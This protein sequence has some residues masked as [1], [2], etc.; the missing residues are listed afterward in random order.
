MKPSLLK[1]SLLFILLPFAMHAQFAL[2][3]TVKMLK[4]AGL[5]PD[6][7]QGV[8]ALPVTGKPL[9]RHVCLVNDNVVAVTIDERSVILSNI[10][11]YVKQP[12]DTIIMGGYHGM[13][14]IL[15]RD[16]EPVGYLCGVNSNWFRPYNDIVGDK[17]ISELLKSPEQF[18]LS[19]AD[20]PSFP[21]PMHPL[22]VYRKSYTVDRTHTSYH[23]VYPL[24]HEIYL[25]FSE[26]LK[27]GANYTI[28]FNDNPQFAEPLT[29][30]FDDKQLRSEAIHVNLAGY[31]SGNKKTALL[32]TWMG[33]GGSL[34]IPSNKNFHIIKDESGSTVFSGTTKLLS[35]DE[36]EIKSY[37]QTNIYTLDFT[38]LTIPGSYRVV[39]ENI[40]CSFPFEIRNSIWENTAKLIMKGFL[41]QR[42]GI[43]LGPPY[44][45]Y[46]RPRN[47]HPAD[48]VTIHLCDT[49]KFFKPGGK[50]PESG[51]TSVFVRIQASILEDTEVPEAWG[52]WMDAG[53]FD[54]RMSHLYSVRRMMYLH[55]LNP[56]YFKNLD[57]NIPESFNKIPDIIDEAAWCLDLY[58]RT[59][60]IYEEGGASWWV[61]SVEHPRG[62]EPS[63]LNSLPTALVP[64]TPRA[65]LNYAAAAAQMAS[66]TS[67]YNAD[68]SAQ[69]LESALAA[70]KWVENNPKA[71][72]VF[73]RSSREFYESLA[74]VN[75]YKCTGD[76]DWHDKYAESLGEVF[77]KGIEKDVTVGNVELL[78]NY[79]L[80]K[81]HETDS[82]LTKQC[83]AGIISIADELIKGAGQNAYGILQSP[84]T[85]L[86]RMATLSGLILPLVAADK[87]TG[88][89]VYHDALTQTIQ[90]A[91]GN[92]PMNRSYISG[93]GERFFYP[94]QIDW[95][96]NNMNIPSGIP[97]FGPIYQTK[98][99]WGWTGSWA[100]DAIEGAGLYPN[101]L[102]TWPHAEK[103]FNQAWIAPTNEFTV[104][105]PMGELLLLT[106]YLS[107]KKGRL[108][109]EQP[110]RIK[111]ERNR[112]PSKDQLK[113]LL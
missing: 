109:I 63:W 52:G 66:V 16:G 34:E 41:H 71:P 61:E 11:P 100:I 25:V 103:C 1:L 13:H 104:R 26:D 86:N 101:E 28:K 68:R 91:M 6:L 37:S 94:Y 2:N 46:Q 60:G 90:Y 54:Q 23:Q 78:F 5:Q 95:E 98:G 75:L 31:E 35:S 24:R 10:K 105:T 33:D 29:F 62:G 56:R 79:L 27:S 106:G 40:G 113:N 38:G 7:T 89:K 50:L 112:E 21:G 12:G 45:D 72:D 74:Y 97:T 69:Y 83:K 48:E 76:L 84:D 43:E 49:E 32:S 102:I 22:R 3:G 18:S 39:V 110:L 82:I 51:Q 93:L 57:L 30:H 47:M 58:R 44:T 73:G 92:N 36:T 4:Y 107:Q 81:D 70:M 42:S 17:L 19:S 111:R 67:R 65:S 9:V 59:Q 15:H 20:D 87:F 99:G 14:K 53:D 108:E 55:E 88:E 80:I 96:A 77:K 64:P 85:D 8:S